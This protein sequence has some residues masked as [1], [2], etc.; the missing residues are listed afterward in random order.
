M[1]RCLA[2]AIF[3]NKALAVQGIACLVFPTLW[4]VS[5]TL[6]NKLVH[7][8]NGNMPTQR[9]ASPT[10]QRLLRI[11][12]L[13]VG[14]FHDSVKWQSIKQLN[15]DLLILTETHLQP[16]L[17]ESI[18]HFF[19]DCY[20]CLSPGFNNEHFTG[21]AVLARKSVFWTVKPLDWN[22]QSPCYKFHAENRLLGFQCWT[23][24]GTIPTFV[25]AAYCPSGGRW[26]RPKR[27]YSHALLNAVTEDLVSRGNPIAI[28]TG[29]LNL[30]LEDSSVLRQWS[31]FG[32]WFD[33]CLVNPHHQSTPTCYH[34]KNGSRIDFI[35]LSR[36]AFDL[37]RHY[38]VFAV[39]EIKTHSAIQALL[40]FPVASQVRNTK[41]PV[42]CL[43]VLQ[44]P[45][46]ASLRLVPKIPASFQVALASGDVSQAFL[47]WSKVAEETL[48]DIANLQGHEVNHQKTKRGHIK[49][50]FLMCAKAKIQ[51]YKLEKSL[52]L[53]EEPEK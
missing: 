24:D 29:D 38:D 47:I 6:L 41:R 30:Q 8:L 9:A 37:C 28:P 2:V 17:H 39:P 36:S 52:K 1:L 48:Y 10:S 4:F 31:R 42:T 51:L 3:L 16:V 20:V 5:R 27:E 34:G 40:T 12:N 32:P 13:N 18:R 25:F 23:G 19:G 33:S 11:V 26:E 43:P 7:I 45:G 15:F 44:P 14:G 49:V 50:P 53:S 35:L 21:V 46:E 22:D